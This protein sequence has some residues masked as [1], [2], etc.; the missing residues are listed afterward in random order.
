[1]IEWNEQLTIQKDD[2]SVVVYF[3]K[4]LTAIESFKAAGGDALKKQGYKS[5]NAATEFQTVCVAEIKA[6]KTTTNKET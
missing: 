2:A 4:Q 5:R 3:T 1:M 6:N